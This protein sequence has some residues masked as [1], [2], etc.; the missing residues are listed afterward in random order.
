MARRQTSSRGRSGGEGSGRVTKRKKPPPSARPGVEARM[1]KCPF[2]H[3]SSPVYAKCKHETFK[4]ARDLR[5]VYILLRRSTSSLTLKIRRHIKQ[6]VKAFYCR[7]CHAYKNGDPTRKDKHESACPGPESPQ[8][9]SNRKHHSNPLT[10]IEMRIYDYF[11]TD[12]AELHWMAAILDYF[13]CKAYSCNCGQF[14]LHC[15]GL[16]LM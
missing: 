1:F 8:L 5:Q 15:W 16:A 7:V 6:F 4:S 11:Q 9:P 12:R 2:R 3:H 13:G 10:A 14:T